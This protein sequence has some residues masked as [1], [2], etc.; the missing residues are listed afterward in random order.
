MAADSVVK[1]PV[2]KNMGVKSGLLTESHKI[3]RI[4]EN[5]VLRRI[6][7]DYTKMHG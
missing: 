7:G 3:R 6:R 5:R 4:F 2:E 1:Q